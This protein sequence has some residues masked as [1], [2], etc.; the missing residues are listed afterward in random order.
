MRPYVLHSTRLSPEPGDFGRVRRRIAKLERFD[1]SHLGGF[2]FILRGASSGFVLLGLMGVAER[3]MTKNQ[4]KKQREFEIKMD[5]FQLQMQL[6]EAKESQPG[7]LEMTLERFAKLQT[8]S[9]YEL[10]AMKFELEQ[11]S[12]NM[13]SMF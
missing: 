9:D 5:E 6:K 10:E 2:H 11:M 12:K 13:N 3:A 7:N 1:S 8:L 4:V